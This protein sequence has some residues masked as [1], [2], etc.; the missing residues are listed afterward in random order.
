[1][2][3]HDDREDARQRELGHQQR[4]GDER[5]AGE[6]ARRT[7]TS[8][9]SCAESVPFGVT[10]LSRCCAARSSSAPS[11]WAAAAAGRAVRRGAAARGVRLGVRLLVAGVY[12]VGSVVCH[13]LPERS[14][15]LW[16]AQMPVC[17]RCTGIY[18][19]AAIAAIV[20][21]AGATPAQADRREATRSRRRRCALR[22]RGVAADARRR[23]STNGRPASTPANWIRA[24][25]GRRRSARARGGRRCTRPGRGSMR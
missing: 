8:P 19:G 21:V 23:S 15:H 2:V 7:A 16:A 9:E 22:S 14:F 5:D 1:M 18:A 3:V 24:A 25:A 4:G 6:V 11:L 12:A 17:A 20:G 13:Q 10:E